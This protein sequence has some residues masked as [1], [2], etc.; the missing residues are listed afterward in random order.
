LLARATTEVQAHAPAGPLTM[1]ALSRLPVLSR[2]GREAQRFGPLGPRAV[3]RARRQFEVGGH[4]V[5]GDWTVYLALTLCNRDPAIYRE[6]DRFD[7]DRFGPDRA[8]HRQHRM[9]FL[10]QGAEPT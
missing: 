7:P 3:G 8:E 10:P 9:A 1:E 5:P 2:G 6:P 4:R